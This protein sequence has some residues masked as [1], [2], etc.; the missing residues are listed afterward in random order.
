MINK[1]THVTQGYRVPRIVIKDIIL[2]VLTLGIRRQPQIKEEAK[3]YVYIFEQTRIKIVEE[4]IQGNRREVDEKILKSEN[5]K[6][7]ILSKGK[8][9]AGDFVYYIV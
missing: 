9:V 2:S 8:F 6:K 4:D 5:E 3:T 7:I 1:D